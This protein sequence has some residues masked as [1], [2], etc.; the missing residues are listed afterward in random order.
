[1]YDRGKTTILNE[2]ALVLV[3]RVLSVI[4]YVPLQGVLSYEQITE[5]EEDID[6]LPWDALYFEDDI[7]MDMSL[8]PSPEDIVIHVEQERLVRE[9]LETL[10]FM[11]KAVLCRR[12]GFEDGESKFLREIAKHFGLSKE[13]IRQIE[14][15]ALWRLRFNDTLKE[16][17]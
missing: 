8:Y 7:L 2:R 4:E 14:A 9:A 15:K 10:P 11:E 12:F 16:L 3:N 5:A 13:R 1:M 6:D 17:V